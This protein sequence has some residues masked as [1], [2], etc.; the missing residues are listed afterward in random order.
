MDAVRQ[1]D[2]L[3]QPIEV[4]RN[5]RRPAIVRPSHPRERDS[6]GPGAGNWAEKPFSRLG[7]PTEPS[8]CQPADRR[9]LIVNPGSRALE[10]LRSCRLRNLRGRGAGRWRIHTPCPRSLSAD[11]GVPPRPAH[12]SSSGETMPANRTFAA[13]VG[14]TPVSRG[15]PESSQL[16]ESHC[17]PHPEDAGSLVVT[18][19]AAPAM[20]RCRNVTVGTGGKMCEP[21]TAFPKPNW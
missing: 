3:G 16:A 4:V 11:R 14:R 20:E 5:D 1:A 6:S 7:L 15:H 21:A 18:G 2:V 17:E 12:T 10:R 13:R 19:L 8:P 9:D